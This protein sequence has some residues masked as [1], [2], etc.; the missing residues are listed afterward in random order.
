MA[1]S[2]SIVGAARQSSSASVLPCALSMMTKL[3]HPTLRNDTWFAGDASVAQW[4]R[5]AEARPRP[6]DRPRVAGARARVEIADG[7]AELE[8]VRRADAE[9]L[10]APQP[11]LDAPPPLW[12]VAAA[13]A[14]DGVL[15]QS[16]SDLVAQVLQHD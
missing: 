12:E 3:S 13:V 5:A 8:R 1:C 6:G 4:N 2:C 16:I 7:D 15:G 11:F 10:P 14:H 9:D